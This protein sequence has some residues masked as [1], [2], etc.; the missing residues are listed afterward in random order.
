MD[1]RKGENRERLDGEILRAKGEVIDFFCLEFEVV[2]GEAI[3]FLCLEY[4]VVLQLEL[5][6]E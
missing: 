4:E 5:E 3:D 6:L 2:L 1:R